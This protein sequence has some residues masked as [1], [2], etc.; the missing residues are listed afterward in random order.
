M[1]RPPSACAET[2]PR[3]VV[4]FGTPEFAVP[5]LQ[6]LHRAGYE[7]ALVVSQPDKPA[8]R[9]QKLAATPVKAAAG[10]LH[11]PVFQPPSLR[12][13]EVVAHLAQ[14]GAD[15]F[16]VAAYGKIFP[17]S[18]LELPQRG[19]VNVH[20]SLL[21]RY[22][23][24]API[25]WAILNGDSETGVSIML[26]TEEM[27]AGPVLLQRRVSIGAEE[28]Y[29]ELQQRLA[30][31]GASALLEAL[32][33][34]LAGSLQPQ[35]QDPSL[36]T[37][38]PLIR[39]EHGRIWWTSPAEFICRQVRALN[40]W[41]G[42]FFFWR[43]RL[44]KVHRARVSEEERPGLPPGTVITARE[45]LVVQTGAGATE[46]LELQMEGRRRLPAKDFLA[47]QGLRP[48]EVLN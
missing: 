40:P 4:F 24:A 2:L 5:S 39:K 15:L 38:A 19:C 43:D 42:A 13:P 31:L 30:V 22:R 32:S 29:G 16:V 9:G 6:A 1:S 25:Q 26:M 45:R 34:W 18:V 17:R 47:G 33:G 35:E 23:G 10:C 7:I 20:A 36:V 28:T 14:F 3:R 44:I 37:F 46:L 8:G 11:L 41:P 48:G 27:D 21:P 12:S